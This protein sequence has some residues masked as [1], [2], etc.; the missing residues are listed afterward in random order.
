[1]KI[2]YSFLQGRLLV[3]FFIATDPTSDL[4]RIQ[5]ILNIATTNSCWLHTDRCTIPPR[6]GIRLGPNSI[7]FIRALARAP[8]FHK[9]ANEI[10]RIHRAHLRGAIL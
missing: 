7:G 1:M 10:D 9:I 4:G 3:V 5:T 8:G 6:R 2:E